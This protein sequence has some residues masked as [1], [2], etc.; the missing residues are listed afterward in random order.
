MSTVTFKKSDFPFLYLSQADDLPPGWRGFLSSME[1]PGDPAILTLKKTWDLTGTYWFAPFQPESPDKFSTNLINF[2][3]RERQQGEIMLLWLNDPNADFFDTDNTWRLTVAEVKKAGRTSYQTSNSLNIIIG[4]YV[5]FHIPIH[6]LVLFKEEEQYIQIVQVD[7]NPPQPLMFSPRDASTK[8]VDKTVYVPFGGPS[9]GAFRFQLEAYERN[10][11]SGFDVGLNYAYTPSEHTDPATLKFPIFRPTDE[12]AALRFYVSVDPVDQWNHQSTEHEPRTYLAFDENSN[13]LSSHYR[14]QFGLEVWLKPSVSYLTEDLPYKQPAR[15]CAMFV[16]CPLRKD[17]VSDASPLYMVPQGAYHIVVQETKSHPSMPVQILCGLSGTE[18]IECVPQST[19]YA[20]DAFLFQSLKPAYSPIF[21]GNDQSNSEED[22]KQLLTDLYVTAWM[23]V[24]RMEE[25]DDLAIHCIHY[26]SQPEEDS[27]F[28]PFEK[29]VLELHQPVMAD[30]T[31]TSDAIFVPFVPHCGIMPAAD[32]IEYE[33]ERTIITIAR[34]GAMDNL[35]FRQQKEGSLST[36]DHRTIATPR[37]LLLTDNSGMWKNLTLARNVSVD[38]AVVSLMFETVTDCLKNAL[39]ANQLFLVISHNRNIGSFLNKIPITEWPFYLNVPQQA[40]DNNVYRNVMIFKYCKG[41]LLE[42]IKNPKHWT[43]PDS[44][45]EQEKLSE[46][47][48]WLIAHCESMDPNNKNTEKFRKLLNDPEW[49]GIVAMHVD[50]SLLDLPSELKCLMGGIDDMNNLFAHH[51]GIQINRIRLAEDGSGEMKMDDV[52]SLFGYIDYNDKSV[53]SKQDGNDFKVTKLGVFFDNSQLVSFDASMYINIGSLFGSKV[54]GDNRIMHFE[55]KRE[56]HNFIPEYSFHSVNPIEI[57]LENS[58]LDRLSLTKATFQMIRDSGNEI[59][60]RF[61]FW[62]EMKFH[63]DLPKDVFSYGGPNSALVFSDLGIRMHVI[64][65]PNVHKP[66]KTFT[67][68]ASTLLPDLAQ[69]VMRTGSLAAGF[70]IQLNRFLA[71]MSPVEL[72]KSGYIPII[73]ESTS[74]AGVEP[75]AID[76]S[77]QWYGL[78]YSLDLGS[79][80]SLSSNN[81]LS[82]NC[83]ICWSN[84]NNYYV[85][86]QV[87]GIRLEKMMVSLQQVI[88]TKFNSVR[89]EEKGGVYSLVLENMSQLFFGKPLEPDPAQGKIVAFVDPASDHKLCNLGWYA[90]YKSES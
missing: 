56:V 66:Q 57:Q 3:N 78:E 85:G 42:H 43:N 27:W 28:R 51:I 58:I 76:E 72:Q 26:L 69:S 48:R 19:D 44:F 24:V 70:P 20:G 15:R 86:L 5:S 35:F 81:N 62:G 37:G 45:N 87:P 84:T 11:Y 49:N 29:G 40:G 60:T 63:D 90:G 10:F 74:G 8:V 53:R 30:L 54:K 13:E 14:T 79:L 67:F 21:P 34:K 17:V 50:L 75:L 64:L 25:R 7:S 6:S 2:A 12:Y 32:W 4:E 18:T 59:E 39:L 9:I 23:T 31:S 83:A 38:N 41:T 16:F 88:D 22:K 46:L 65:P 73:T 80:G 1:P 61:S 47:S 33:Y 71:D 77:E 82:C 52:S 68:D 55:G 36:G 89:L